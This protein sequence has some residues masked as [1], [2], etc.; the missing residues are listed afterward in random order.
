[1]MS[2]Q[3]TGSTGSAFCV[4]ELVQIN[5]PANHLHGAGVRLVEHF[6]EDRCICKVTKMLWKKVVAGWFSQHR[7]DN[8]EL[9]AIQAVLVIGVELPMGGKD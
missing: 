3:G 9:E 8:L 5:E 1:M 2:S 4:G 6:G 7:P